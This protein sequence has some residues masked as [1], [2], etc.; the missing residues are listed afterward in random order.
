MKIVSTILFA[1]FILLSPLQKALAELP[2]VLHGKRAVL[3]GTCVFK[4]GVF[5]VVGR[6]L[7]VPPTLGFVLVTC[8]MTAENDSL[9][10]SWLVLLDDKGA[11]SEIIK[12]TDP[13]TYESVY[14]PLKGGI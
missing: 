5:Q 8:V 7:I 13:A 11:I 1:L 14:K 3:V 4:D 10:P 2:E 12:W 6:N 9:N